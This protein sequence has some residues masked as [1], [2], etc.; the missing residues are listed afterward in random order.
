[1]I[2]ISCGRQ[3]GEPLCDAC[4]AKKNDL[5]TIT[6]NISVNMCKVCGS[7]TDVSA[8]YNLPESLDDVIRKEVKTK[9][10]IFNVHIKSRKVG[11]KMDVD[12]NVHGRFAERNVGKKETKKIF[13]TITGK[14]CQNC[15]KLRGNYY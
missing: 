4:Y 9:N 10:K 2:C 1:M 8:T 13:V 7:V 14:M 11:N 3:S 5:F 6:K 15:I 12:V